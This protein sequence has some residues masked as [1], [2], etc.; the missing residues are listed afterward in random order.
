MILGIFQATRC[1]VLHSLANAKL[2][3]VEVAPGAYTLGVFR[4]ENEN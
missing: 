3:N 1:S 4:V 2:A